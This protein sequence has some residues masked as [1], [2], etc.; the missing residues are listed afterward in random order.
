MSATTARSSP[1]GR[2]GSTSSARAPRRPCGASA[3]CST[4]V[5]DRAARRPRGLLRRVGQHDGRREVAAEE[6]VHLA[7][8]VA[9]AVLPRVDAAQLGEVVLEL[10]RRVEARDASTAEA[11]VSASAADD[12][13]HGPALDEARRARAHEAAR[14]IRGAGRGPRRSSLVEPLRRSGGMSTNAVTHDAIMPMPAD[15]PEL[16][17]PA[18]LGEHERRVR[19]RRPRAPPRGCRGAR[20]RRRRRAR[21]RPDA[22]R[23]RSSR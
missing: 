1:A 12:D 5:A 6:G 18:E 15:E 16:P 17:E 19:R 21:P 9:L 8:P 4:D 20:P 23:R 7:A 10:R 14:P 13:G 22:P 11:T 2:S 3:P